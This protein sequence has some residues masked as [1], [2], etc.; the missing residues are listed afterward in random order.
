MRMQWSE[1]AIVAG[2]SVGLAIGGFLLYQYLGKTSTEEPP[3][4]VRD[5][6]GGGI[7]FGSERGSVMDLVV[8]VPIVG[9]SVALAGA[10]VSTDDTGGYTFLQVVPGGY[11][12]V[13][14]A[15]GYRRSAA[16]TVNV[17][18]GRVIV[19]NFSLVAIPAP[20]PSP[21]LVEL[22]RIYAEVAVGGTVI[23]VY[24]LATE[25]IPAGWNYDGPVG[26]IGTDDSPAPLGMVPLYH[27]N[28]G[29]Q[30][31]FY[32]IERSPPSGYTARE[33]IGY[34]Y[35]PTANLSTLPIG[36]LPLVRHYNRHWGV[37]YYSTSR[38]PPPV[39]DYVYDRLVAYIAPP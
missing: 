19:A 34:V 24:A 2:V 3:P 12:L 37:S 22:K 30:D 17:R 33:M 6:P 39:G 7:V 28:S 20:P 16:V 23:T 4:D 13:V 14:N 29:V 31:N 21:V 38:T 11:S 18:E 32:S 8:G 25:D 26:E 36:T 35:P 27:S 15:S 1:V 5:E 9:A 10:T